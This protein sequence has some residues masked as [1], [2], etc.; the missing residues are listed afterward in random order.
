MEG[1]VSAAGNVSQ[2]FEKFACSRSLTDEWLASYGVQDNAF[3]AHGMN[4]DDGVDAAGAAVGKR[5]IAE[6]KTMLRQKLECDVLR[7]N[8]VRTGGASLMQTTS[9]R[10]ALQNVK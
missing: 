4:S 7:D 6:S 2:A 9:C 1:Q 8:E 10:T 5:V 3:I